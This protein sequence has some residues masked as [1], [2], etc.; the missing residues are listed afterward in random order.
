MQQILQTS[1]NWHL[2]I[3]HF[4]STQ[5]IA[6][7]P[8]TSW[9]QHQ[10][11]IQYLYCNTKKMNHIFLKIMRVKQNFTGH[12]NAR[13]EQM[14]GAR[15]ITQI[16]EVIFHGQEPWW[17]RPLQTLHQQ[18]STRHLNTATT[19]HQACHFSKEF[20]LNLQISASWV[21]TLKRAKVG[22]RQNFW[23]C[24][25]ASKTSL[26]VWRNLVQ[27]R[28]HVSIDCVIW[29]SF[30]L[31][32]S[33]TSRPLLAMHALAK[34]LQPRMCYTLI[35]LDSLNKWGWQRLWTKPT[36]DAS[37]IS[38]WVTVTVLQYS[39]YLLLQ[40]INEKGLWNMKPLQRVPSTML[41]NLLDASN[42]ANLVVGGNQAQRY[43]LK[44][45]SRK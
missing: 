6:V 4:V 37:E 10:I 13:I 25:F 16:Q 45:C 17:L 29:S 7:P 15:L 19:E 36:N 39:L 24:H 30:H 23:M 20:V 14:L 40:L 28:C 27:R 22:I 38:E 32:A 21:E 41:W 42:S 8:V 44:S 9:W 31:L 35:H 18:N 26:R 12:C 5:R 43:G 1:A 2:C 34:Q 33:M 3:G 11:Q